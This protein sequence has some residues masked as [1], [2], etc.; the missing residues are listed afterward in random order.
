MSVSLHVSNPSTLP[1]IP[2]GCIAP[3][4]RACCRV[5]ESMWQSLTLILSFCE[6]VAKEGLDGKR[7]IDPARRGDSTPRKK[8]SCAPRSS[9]RFSRVGKSYERPG[10]FRNQ[11]RENAHSVQQDETALQYRSYY[12][13]TAFLFSF[14][15]FWEGVDLRPSGTRQKE[16]Q[17][18]HP[19][20]QTVYFVASLCLCPVQ[21]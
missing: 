10:L 18:I 21:Y 19:N 17:W 11:T 3:C 16:P 4:G 5:A 9:H 1:L 2:L 8:R 7:A 15:L 14:V 6:N 13:N 20:T 12:F